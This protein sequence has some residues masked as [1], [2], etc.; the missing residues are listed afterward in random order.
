[1]F[2]TAVDEFPSAEPRDA[3]V[4][5][6]ESGVAAALQALGRPAE[7][8]EWLERCR[9]RLTESRLAPP[10]RRRA[11]ERLIRTLVAQGDAAGAENFRVSLARLPR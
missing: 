3:R 4:A 1:W 2:R 7:S 6:A 5:I 8:T 11:Y 10:L 9:R